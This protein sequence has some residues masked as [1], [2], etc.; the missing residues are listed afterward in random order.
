MINLDIN[1]GDICLGGRFKNHRFTVKDI[2]T[3]QHGQPT[4]NGRPILKFRIEKL[5]S[6]KEIK[7]MRKAEFREIIREEIR[8]ILV[9]NVE[10]YFDA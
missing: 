5:M 2:G 3:D 9:E 1:V 8:S 10:Y 6:K 7:E 4:I